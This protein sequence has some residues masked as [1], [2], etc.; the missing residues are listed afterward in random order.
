M[1]TN[2]ITV[3]LGHIHVYNCFMYFFLYADIN[4]DPNSN[5]NEHLAQSYLNNSGDTFHLEQFTYKSDALLDVIFNHVKN[6]SFMG[7]S[8]CIYAS[9]VP[10]TY[11]F[12]IIGLYLIIG[13]CLF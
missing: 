11:I 10:Q 4:P 1:K 3:T 5:L 13:A 12:N 6:T 2:T 7:I 8:V 9:H